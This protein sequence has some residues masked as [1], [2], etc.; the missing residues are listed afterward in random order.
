MTAID[1][2]QL[3][4]DSTDTGADYNASATLP[5]FSALDAVFDKFGGILNNFFAFENHPQIPFYDTPQGAIFSGS[6]HKKV[7]VKRRILEYRAKY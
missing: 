4:T 2:Y 5:D 3:A 6:N 7:Q 1:P